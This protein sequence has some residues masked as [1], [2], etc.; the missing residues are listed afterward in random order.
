MSSLQC[1]ETIGYPGL[2]KAPQFNQWHDTS[3]Q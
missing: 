1:I 3:G 2:D